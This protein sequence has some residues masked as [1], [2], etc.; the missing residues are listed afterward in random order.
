MPKDLEVQ[1]EKKSGSAVLLLSLL[2]SALWP[3]LCGCQLGPKEKAAALPLS[4]DKLV[5]VLVDVHLAEVAGQ[6]L[7][8][9]QRDSLEALYYRQ[10][11][12]IHQVDSAEFFHALALLQKEPE[13][14]REIYD[15]V[16]ERLGKMEAQEKDGQKKGKK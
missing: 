6:N 14:L 13:Q 11:F 7:I 15:R 16:I 1:R 2:L 9:P 10:I 5:E 4:E 3:G 12:A 8:G